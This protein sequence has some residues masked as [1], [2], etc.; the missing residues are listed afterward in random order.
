MGRRY[1]ASHILSLGTTWEKVV[2]LTL[3]KETRNPF[4]RKLSEP[5][6]QSELFEEGKK[7][8]LPVGIR[9]PD[10]TA[11]SRVAITTMLPRP[12]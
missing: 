2:Y 7:L 12:P 11:R 3:G 10:L 4:N 9:T 6:N 8:L 5:Q 1:L